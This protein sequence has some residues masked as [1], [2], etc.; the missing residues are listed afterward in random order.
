MYCRKCG[1]A[2]GDDDKFCFNCGNLLQEESEQTKK[3]IQEYQVTEKEPVSIADEEIPEFIEDEETLID[4]SPL[5]EN[6]KEEITR[7]DDIPDDFNPDDFTKVVKKKFCKK[8]DRERMLFGK[9]CWWCGSELET[10][11]HAM[12][13]TP[14]EMS[15][16][17]AEIER[18]KK[19]AE[20][21]KKKEED[22]RKKLIDEQNKERETQK[23][24][25]ITTNA[26]G[27]SNGTSTDKTKKKKKRLIIILSSIAI[28]LAAIFFIGVQEQQRQEELARQTLAAKKEYFTTYNEIMGHISI[29]KFLLDMDSS[30]Q[31]EVFRKNSYGDLNGAVEK[32]R[33]DNASYE[34]TYE[35]RTKK[36]EVLVNK[37]LVKNTNLLSEDAEYKKLNELLDKTIAD[38]NSYLEDTT[39]PT[40]TYYTY[41][42]SSNEK[43]KKLKQ[44]YSEMETKFKYI[45]EANG[46]TLK[47]IQNKGKT[48]NK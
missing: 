28:I 39:N 30:G 38:L 1:K 42:D 33:K 41:S 19:I 23:Q 36:I 6:N 20:Q 29:M 45:L 44:S 4:D 34:E 11:E 5:E 15:H 7:T 47:D 9:K 2:V 8:C 43:S 17:K 24:E 27:N 48:Q 14:N 35:D 26:D 13:L 40:G 31:T 12:K 10:I 21:N 22:K 32:Y 25:A 16:K 18:K 3:N 46:L 37:E